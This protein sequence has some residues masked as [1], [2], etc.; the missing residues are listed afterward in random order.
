MSTK[1]KYRYH[2][3]GILVHHDDTVEPIDMIKTAVSEAQAMAY[4]CIRNK[5]KIGS[6]HD[7][8]VECL[9]EVTESSES[10]EVPGQINL[11][12]EIVVEENKLRQ[13]FLTC[14]GNKNALVIVTFNTR[15][16]DSGHKR[17]EIKGT[18]TIDGKPESETTF[19]WIF[20]AYDKPSL[21]RNGRL[22][23]KEYREFEQETIMRILKEAKE[24]RK[25]NHQTVGRR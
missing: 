22:V 13:K 21:Y 25:G 23:P 14:I 2:I 12:G 5:K 4:C 17:N 9:G 1:P 18:V 20:P 24:H 11:E 15:N 16:I 7:A 3:T 10:K 19:H 6:L 8:R